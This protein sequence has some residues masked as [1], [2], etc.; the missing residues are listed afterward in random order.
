LPVGSSLDVSRE[1]SWIVL[2]PAFVDSTSSNRKGEDLREKRKVLLLMIV[3]GR[4]LK[5]ATGNANV[6]R[7]TFD[8]GITRSLSSTDD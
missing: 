5:M 2:H 6:S 3:G 7:E 8:T 1:T 4:G